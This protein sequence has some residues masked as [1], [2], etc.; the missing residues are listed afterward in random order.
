[1][2]CWT[3]LPPVHLIQIQG[4]F[5]SQ[6]IG[7]FAASYKKLG[8][9]GDRLSIYEFNNKEFVLLDCR[10]IIPP[11]GAISSLIKNLHTAHVGID[12]TMSLAKQ[13]FFWHGMLND[14]TMT[15][16]SCR[17][18]QL[19]VPSQ[20]KKK[21]V[22]SPLKNVS[23]SFKEWAADL[24][25]LHSDDYLVLV[26]RLTGFFCCDKLNK[27]STAIILLKITSWFNLLGWPETIQMRDWKVSECIFVLNWKVSESESV[28][29]GKCQNWKV[30]ELEGVRIGK[31]Q[32]W[33]VSELES[34]RIGK[35]QNRKV[36]ELESVRIIWSL[37]IPYK[38]DKYCLSSNYNICHVPIGVSCTMIWYPS[39]I[40]PIFKESENSDTFWF[41]HFPILTLSDSD[42]FQFW[43]FRF[44]HFPI[45]TLSN[46]DTFQFW[47]F[48]ILTLSN[49]DTFQFWHFPILTLSYSDTFQ[50][51]HFPISS[52]MG[53]KWILT[54]SNSDTFQSPIQTDGGPQFRSK[55]NGFCKNFFIHH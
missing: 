32:N 31:C 42:T 49:S 44:W 27:T 33:K 8:D 20:K 22:S 14:I 12:R 48:P 52:K 51:W 9:L 28:R 24:F 23:F 25:S 46:S 54:L 47:H 29:I 38:W 35:C 18:C 1:M 45:L 39:I 26:D 21:I 50:F 15:I 5:S 53:K 43:H 2:P 3:H 40:C 13:L 37:K 17:A 41:W 4:N 30:S 36:S 11:P 10:Q 55:F 16:N 34:V 19:Y 6:Q 7:P